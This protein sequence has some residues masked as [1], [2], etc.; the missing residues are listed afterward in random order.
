MG[1]LRVCVCNSC[2]KEYDIAFGTGLD[3]ITLKFVQGIYACEEC[4]SWEISLFDVSRLS[5]KERTEIYDDVLKEN[6]ELKYIIDKIID[7]KP[8]K[9]CPNCKKTMKAFFDLKIEGT[10]IFPK[11]ICKE[12]RTELSYKYSGLWD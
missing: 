3:S 6:P 2:K 7:F 1:A 9:E 4:E 8:E 10:S 5:Q 12:C 11:L